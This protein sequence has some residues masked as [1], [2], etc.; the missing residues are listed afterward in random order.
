MDDEIGRKQIDCIQEFVLGGW[1]EIHAQL[2]HFHIAFRI[3]IDDFMN[4]F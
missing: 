1:C 2:L 4:T 3:P